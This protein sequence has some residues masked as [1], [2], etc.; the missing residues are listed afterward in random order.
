MKRISRY[1]IISFPNLGF[2]KNRLE[3]LVKGKMPS[4]VLFDFKWYNT[5]HI[6]V[7]SIKDFFDIVEESGLKVKAHLFEKSGNSLKDLLMKNMPNL[8]Q[9]IPV[10][11]L[12]KDNE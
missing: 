4:S 5:G 11:L 7:F 8:F 3:L 9:L 10:F 1:Q 2:Y 12:E 6:H